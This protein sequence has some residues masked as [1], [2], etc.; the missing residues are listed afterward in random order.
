MKAAKPL[1][2]AASGGG[3]GGP[4]PIEAA[5]VL[6]AAVDGAAVILGRDTAVE[7][8]PGAHGAA[9]RRQPCRSKLVVPQEGT[10]SLIT[11]LKASSAD[12]VANWSLKLVHGG[13]TECL[14]PS[15]YSP[16]DM[17]VR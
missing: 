12:A 10:A 6:A 11:A 1:L 15:L 8:L 16:A 5:A 9:S 3:G 17:I 13:P 14:R 7:T 2:P 4:G